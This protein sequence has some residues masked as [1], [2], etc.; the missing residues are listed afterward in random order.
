MLRVTRA[1]HVPKYLGGRIRKDKE[2]SE[3]SSQPR[4]FLAECQL[5]ESQRSKEKESPHLK[6]AQTHYFIYFHIQSNIPLFSQQKQLLLVDREALCCS[7]RRNEFFPQR[8]K[9][10]KY[11]VVCTTK[12]YFPPEPRTDTT[13]QPARQTTRTFF[14]GRNKTFP[15]QQKNCLFPPV[16]KTDTTAQPTRQTTRTFFFRSQ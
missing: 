12:T 16:P 6:K 1:I 14:S 2:N 11:I 9:Y 8:E 5:R 3:M 15:L 13:A 7:L 4:N 10:S